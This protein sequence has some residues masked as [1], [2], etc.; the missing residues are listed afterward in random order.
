MAPTVQT[1]PTLLVVE[2]NDDSRMAICALLR[3]AGYSVV[4]CPHG[5]PALDYLRAGNRPSLILLDMLMPVVDGWH[6]LEEVRQ[7]P[8]A[9]D[10]PILVVTGTILTPAWAAQNGCAGILRK[11]IDATELLAKAKL[12]LRPNG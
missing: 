7:L 3:E 8:T 10:L 5:G 6:L 9:A 11:P 12:C 1:A 2:D 4:A